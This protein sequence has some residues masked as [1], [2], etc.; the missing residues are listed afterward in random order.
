MS[1]ELPQTSP[2]RTLTKRYILALS[3]VA[4]LSIAGQLGIQLSIKHQSSDAV[5][6]NVAGR[7]RMLSQ[8][9]TKAT[10]AIQSTSDPNMT[11]QYVQELQ[12]VVNLWRNLIKGYKLA[13]PHWDCPEIIVSPC[14][15]YLPRL[16]PH[17]KPC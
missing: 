17:I 7:Q 8:K 14:K 16:K 3:T 1:Q 13:N 4:L 11:H 5:V 2:S 6:I 15:N 10:L 9:L 12:E